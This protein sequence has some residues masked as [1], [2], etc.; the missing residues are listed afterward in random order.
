MVCKGRVRNGVVV[1]EG[2]TQLP[3]G[4]EVRVETIEPVETLFDRL[5]HVI[6]KAT[7]LPEDLAEQHDHYLY[8]LPKS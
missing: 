8:G 7:D 6:G 1:L 4:T 2:D 3:E 5:Q